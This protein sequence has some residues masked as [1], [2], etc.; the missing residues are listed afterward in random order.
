MTIRS[1]ALIA[2]FAGLTGGIAMAQDTCSPFAT[3]PQLENTT[4]VAATSVAA[5]SAQG[6]PAHC[7][8]QATISPVPGSKIGAVY[9][10]P[11]RWNGKVLG[12]GGGGFAGN[13]RAA[14]AA[15]GLSRGYAVIQ[16]DLGHPSANA[17]DPSFAF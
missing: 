1:H 16:N 14:A 15:E 5:D 6:V 9:R 8:V 10:L 12:I 3:K 7:E 13:V 4:I 2:A 11:A 17:L